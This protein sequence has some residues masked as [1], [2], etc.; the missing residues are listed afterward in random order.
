[1]IYR[2]SEYYPG[3]LLY[4]DGSGVYLGKDPRFGSGEFSNT[5]KKKIKNRSVKKHRIGRSNSFNTFS[6]RFQ[7]DFEAVEQTHKKN[8]GIL[9]LLMFPLPPFRDA[10]IEALLFG[11]ET[12]S[13]KSFREISS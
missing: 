12:E 11:I 3:I 2:N 9:M 1:M 10:K 13:E 7:S 6:G 5:K 8:N 4:S